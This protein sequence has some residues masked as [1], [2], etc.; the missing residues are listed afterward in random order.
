MPHEHP[1]QYADTALK[2]HHIKYLP[3]LFRQGH[4]AAVVD[5][6]V[7]IFGGSSGGGYGGQHSD[8]TSDP[9]YLNDLFLL[10]G[11]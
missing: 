9:V 2:K 5:K 1:V 4:A 6:K 8:T 3:C 11:T 7:Y 10:Q